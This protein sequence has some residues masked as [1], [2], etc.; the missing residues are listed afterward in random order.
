M[1]D[2]RRGWG[3]RE[4]DVL[5]GQV[6]PVAA[7][8]GTHLQNLATQANAAH[9]ACYPAWEQT[10]A[11][12]ART[13]EY[14]VDA[15]RALTEARQ[16]VPHGQWGPWMAANCPQISTQRASEYTR[17]YEA[18]VS[19]E[20]AQIPAGGDLSLKD[21]IKL[22]GPAKGPA[23][24]APGRARKAVKKITTMTVGR[25][26]GRTMHTISASSPVLNGPRGNELRRKAIRNYL[27]TLKG[28]SR[29]TME[30]EFSEWGTA[31]LDEVYGAD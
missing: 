9:G 26:L 18:S 21:A 3:P 28:G 7:P 5:E 17:Y 8:M 24:A 11:S 23:G 14:A 15:G 27:D 10:K 13:V 19:G 16:H 6:I 22:L 25:A 29:G 1:S 2:E 31:M 20:L 12:M 30:R 4:G